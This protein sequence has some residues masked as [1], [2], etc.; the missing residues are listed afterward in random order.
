MD[1]RSCPPSCC[2]SVCFPFQLVPPVRMK[3]PA[4]VLLSLLLFCPS[5]AEVNKRR[6]RSAAAGGQK[7]TRVQDR[8]VGERAAGGLSSR[9]QA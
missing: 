1:S 7:E 6:P 2:E 5:Q 4:L 9:L 3:S 8:A